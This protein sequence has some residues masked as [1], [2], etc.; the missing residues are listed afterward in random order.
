MKKFLFSSV[1]LVL[2]LVLV[3]SLFAQQRVDPPMIERMGTR[4]AESA[5]SPI[6]YS[7]Y[8]LDNP[9]PNG[10]FTE[11]LTKLTAEEIIQFSN[12]SF[13]TYLSYFSPSDAG[14]NFQMHRFFDE[15]IE[16]GEF[17]LTIVDANNTAVIS[18][19]FMYIISGKSGTYDLEIQYV[20]VPKE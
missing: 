1:L 9:P 20:F 17:K 7:S 4:T 5:K 19:I 2:S 14:T 16:N 12:I 10:R 18:Q 8:T 6:P 3:T 15:F 11:S 13:I